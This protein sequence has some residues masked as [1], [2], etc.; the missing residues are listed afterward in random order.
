MAGMTIARGREFLTIPGPTNI[1]DAVLAAMHRPAI[2]IYSGEM[3][4]L[5]RSLHEDLPKIFRTSGHTYI[6]AAN[7]H[8][9]WEAAASN[10]LSANTN[11]E[12][13]W[14]VN[15]WTFFSTAEVSW[16]W[17][18]CGRIRAL[19]LEWTAKNFLAMQW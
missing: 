6:Y 14:R 19:I 16:R 11:K 2:D 1:P 15:V 9:G 10:V 3:L 17:I 13:C 8:G 4:E 12:N 5:T 18:V 7:G